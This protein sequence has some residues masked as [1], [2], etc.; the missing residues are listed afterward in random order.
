[1]RFGILIFAAF[2]FLLFSCEKNVLI[3]KFEEI[4]NSEW[5]YKDQKHFEFT[6][7]DT[8]VFY[9]IDL[10]IRHNNEYNF[11]NIYLMMYVTHPDSNTFPQRVNFNLADFTGKW[12]GEGFG[13]IKTYKG[14]ISEYIHFPKPGVYKVNIEQ[15][16]RVNPLLGIE[17]IGLKVKRADEE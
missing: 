4:D 1:M 11:Q 5:N 6:V 10:N 2:S 16:M 9:S 13:G 17:S 7:E 3:N 14:V 15:N 12:L 8:S